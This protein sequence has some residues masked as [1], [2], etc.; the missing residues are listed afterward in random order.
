MN[1]LVLVHLFMG[2]SWVRIL[3]GFLATCSMGRPF[4]VPDSSDGKTLS[5]STGIV[6]QSPP[7]PC[8]TLTLG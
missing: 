3:R 5:K 8:T 2:W 6:L 4:E 7:L 1:Q